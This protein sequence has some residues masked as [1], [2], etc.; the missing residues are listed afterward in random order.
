MAIPWEVNKSDTSKSTS[1]GPFLAE[2]SEGKVDALDLAEPAFGFSLST[3]SQAVGFDL[4]E[5]GQDLRINVD[6]G[7]SHAASLNS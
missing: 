4:I 6:H 2:E 3:A 1:L 5:A 7:T